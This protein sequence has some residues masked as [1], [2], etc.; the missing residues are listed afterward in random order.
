MRKK[1][2]QAAFPYTIPIFAGFWFLALAYGIY[3]NANG[4][5]FVCPMLMSLL[6]YGGSLEFVAVE[7]LL[8]SFAPMQVFIMTL[9]IQ[10]RHI[11]YG[12]SMLDRFKGMGW[13]KF[14]LIFGMCDETFS[15]N[16]TADIPENVDRGWF[17]FFVTLLNQ[18]YWVSGATVGG[19]VGSLLEFDTTGISFV[20]T[21]MF[22]VIFLEQWLKEDNHISSLVGVAAAVV[23]RIC[24]GADSFMLPTMAVIVLLLAASRK[25]LEAM[26][27]A[28]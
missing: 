18:L 24:F 6:I 4:F 22:V 7:M 9:L 3:M 12:I 1:A 28:R 19:L 25:R 11:F 2:F 14:Y 16:Y 17:M 13:K 5:P 8:S 15:V 26:E 10:A 23:C 27:A 20:M 21:A